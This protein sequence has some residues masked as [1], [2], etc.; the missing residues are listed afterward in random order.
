VLIIAIFSV[1][2]LTFNRDFHDLEAQRAMEMAQR[3]NNA[4]GDRINSLNTL[5]EDYAIWDD[6][7]NFV[8]EPEVYQ[9]YIRSNLTETT[10]VNCGLNFLLIIDDTGNIIYSRGYDLLE[11]YFTTVPDSLIQKLSDINL[12][13]HVSLNKS[14]AGVLLLPEMPLLFS[15]EPIMTSHG[16]GPVA[17]AFIMA[18]YL[19]PEILGDLENRILLPVA[20]VPVTEVEALPRNS[21]ISSGSSNLA[22]YK[23]IDS[24]HIAGSIIIPD[25]ENKPALLLT[26]IIPRDIY[27]RGIITT[28]YFLFAVIGLGIIT[29]LV[30]NLL[31]GKIITSRVNQ[32]GAYIDD[33]TKKGE[34]SKRLP[35]RGNDELTHISKDMNNILQTL[36]ESRL[37]LKNKEENEKKLRRMIESTADGFIFTSIAGV[38]TDISDSKVHLFGYSDKKEMLGQKIIDFIIPAEKTRFRDNLEEAFIS[39]NITHDKVTMQKK[40]GSLFQS[41]VQVLVVKEN[42]TTPVGFIISPYDSNKPQVAEFQ[43]S[44]HQ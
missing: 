41:E 6:T 42:E 29:T 14:F 19:D 15:A 36:E 16:D 18:R 12:L 33:F 8:R 23:I 43:A 9:S 5:N 2:Q 44:A 24:K 7:Y 22:N 20:I 40:D 37:A 10:F 38:I 3:A 27:A 25:I 4:L 39:G 11:N 13:N 17:G 32:V 26:I 1:L 31:I 34:F 30:I 35:V 21:Q 28:R